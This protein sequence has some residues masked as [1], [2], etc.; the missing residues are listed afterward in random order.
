MEINGISLWYIY[1][2]KYI[3]QQSLSLQKWCHCHS[4]QSKST[5]HTLY[6]FHCNYFLLKIVPHIKTVDTVLYRNHRKRPLLT[7][8]K[9]ICR[10]IFIVWHYTSA[11]YVWTTSTPSR[12]FVFALWL[13]HA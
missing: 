9:L 8:P 10:V 7:N 13:V 4:G 11:L 1:K 2:K 12:L 3:Q 6:S 5:E